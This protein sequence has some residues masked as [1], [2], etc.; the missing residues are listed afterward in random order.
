MLEPTDLLRTAY[1]DLSEVLDDVARV[2]D[3]WASTG[4]RGWAVHDLTFHP[5]VM[6]DVPSSP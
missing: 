2:G 5:L 3:R 4:C 1:A 6:P